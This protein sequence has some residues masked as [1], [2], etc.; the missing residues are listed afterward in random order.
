LYKLVP[1]WIRWIDN[2]QGFGHKEEFG[3]PNSKF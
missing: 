1:R 3:I 2:T